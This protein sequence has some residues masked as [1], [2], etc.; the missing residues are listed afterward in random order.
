MTVRPVPFIEGNWG[1]GY[2]RD[3]VSPLLTDPGA[4]H[5]PNEP[6]W[7]DGYDESERDDLLEQ[8]ERLRAAIRRVK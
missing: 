7:L 1:A 8:L 6:D 3:V 5:Y 4:N 2:T